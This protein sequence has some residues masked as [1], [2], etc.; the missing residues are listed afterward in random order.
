MLGSQAWVVFSSPWCV[1]CRAQAQLAPWLPVLGDHILQHTVFNV[2]GSE[3]GGAAHQGLYL[4]LLLGILL[5]PG[6]SSLTGQ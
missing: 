2:G 4:S 3:M 6:H 5:P 1:V